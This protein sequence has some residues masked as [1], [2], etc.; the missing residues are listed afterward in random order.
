MRLRTVFA[1]LS[2][3]ALTSACDGAGEAPPPTEPTP[4]APATN[5]AQPEPAPDLQPVAAPCK[6]PELKLSNDGGD[7][8]MGHR[9]AIIGVQNLGA[10]ACS[11]TGYPSVSLEDAAGRAL[12][13]VRTDQ[14]P[15]SYF[16]SGEAPTSVELAP[17]AKAFFD[18]AW[19]V[20]PN[21]AQGEQVCPSA[22]DIL[23][24]PPGDASPVTLAQTFTACGGRIEVSPFRP[25][26]EP[27]A[28]PTP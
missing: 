8:G 17:R 25:V 27:G 6:G 24:T 2:I 9:R 11:L 19:T 23:M 12:T 7:A 5:A 1:T 21:E 15:D 13:T 16:R 3:V 28:A 22:A 10:Q 26:A 20:I 14:H 4:A 18:L